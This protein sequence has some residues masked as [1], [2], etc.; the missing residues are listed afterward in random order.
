MVVSPGGE[1]LPRSAPPHC[2]LFF[3]RGP[4]PA[5]FC[6]SP[7]AVPHLLDHEYGWHKAGQ[8]QVQV[9]VVQIA[10]DEQSA[11]EMERGGNGEMGAFATVTHS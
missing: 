2:L 5:A 11:D 3:P 4:F 10:A 9:Q 8:L 7:G 1:V 6:S